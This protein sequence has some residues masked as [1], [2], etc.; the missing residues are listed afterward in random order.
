MSKTTFNPLSF[1]LRVLTKCHMMGVFLTV[2]S[3]FLLRT[4]TPKDTDEVNK[5]DVYEC[6]EVVCDLDV[7]G[8]PSIFKIIRSTSVLP[9][10]WT[11]FDF[12]WE[13]NTERR[14]WNLEKVTN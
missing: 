1:A 14:Y 13:E 3:G 5:R 7:T 11:I 9:R 10:I 6:D 2:L 4:G 12:S 8:T